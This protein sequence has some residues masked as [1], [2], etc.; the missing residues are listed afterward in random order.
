MDAFAQVLTSCLVACPLLGGI[1]TSFSWCLSAG[2]LQK[3]SLV[4][5]SWFCQEQQVSR[6]LDVGS[7]NF[8]HLVKLASARFLRSEDTDF[9]SV[10]RTSWEA[11]LGWCRCLVTS[12]T[13]SRMILV[14]RDAVPCDLRGSVLEI[15]V[16]IYSSPI[17]DL[18][19]HW[20]K[21]SSLPCLSVYTNVILSLICK[22]RSYCFH[23]FVGV[24]IQDL[25]NG[26]NP[27]PDTLMS[28]P[29]FNISSFSCMTSSICSFLSLFQPGNVL[30]FKEALVLFSR[31]YHP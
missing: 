31:G 26:D 17:Y 21:M 13:P 14:L 7:V 2:R 25:T 10:I 4:F 12:Q 24:Q 11:A 30:S 9:F 28:L 20:G 8:D 22:N 27:H 5:P 18:V 29:F 23:Y 6:V 3:W 16:C 15:S 1:I 19:F